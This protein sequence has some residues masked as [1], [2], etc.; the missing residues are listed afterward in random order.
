MEGEFQK[1]ILEGPLFKKTIPLIDAPVAIDKSGNNWV[2]PERGKE[3]IYNNF[4]NNTVQYHTVDERGEWIEL[5]RNF[6]TA[7][8]D[9]SY[10]S[11]EF[12][13]VQGKLGGNG[14]LSNDG[15]YAVAN[16]TLYTL[17]NY[18]F[19]SVPQIYDGSY[20]SVTASSDRSFFWLTD[21]IKHELIALSFEAR[22]KLQSI[23]LNIGE[24]FFKES[25]NGKVLLLK[26]EE[27]GHVRVFRK[28]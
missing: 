14:Y 4:L 2:F 25:D 7:I 12:K 19:E 10:Y 6:S 1:P 5:S 15:K 18:Y 26:T 16:N 23:N 17:K 11:S 13:N 20:S 24:S 3:T 27:T 8:F 22:D 9:G 21:T 28:K